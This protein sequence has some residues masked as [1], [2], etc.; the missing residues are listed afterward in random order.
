MAD[1]FKHPTALVESNDIGTGTRIW[2]YT[3][4][5]KGAK[6]GEEC[7][8]CDHSFVESGAILGNKVTIKN[9]VSIWDKVTIEDEVFIGPNAA[10]TNDLWPRSKKSDWQIVETLIK[11]GATIGAN[12]TIVCG[13][14]IGQYAMIGA[15]SVVTRD[16]TDYSLYY[17]NPARHHGWVCKCNKKLVFDLN[18]SKCQCGREYQKTQNKISLILE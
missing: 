7:N 14:T 6:I 13:V 5:M 8:I 11:K 2:A 9:G 17:G 18:T 12:A 4:I 1:F 3:H 10:L 15:G 16:V